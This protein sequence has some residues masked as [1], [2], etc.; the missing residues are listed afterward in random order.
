MKD[1]PL[2]P[3]AQTHPRMEQWLQWQADNLAANH[4][5]SLENSIHVLWLAGE[6]VR[7]FSLRKKN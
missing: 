3:S 4:D 5:K 7:T 1:L 2:S 6:A